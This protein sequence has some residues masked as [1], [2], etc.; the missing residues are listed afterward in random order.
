MTHRG[1]AIRDRS[2]QR[3]AF[4]RRR[5]GQLRHRAPR[6]NN[7][8]KRKGWLAPSLQHRIDTTMAWVR[9]LGHLVAE[10]PPGRWSGPTW[11]QGMSPSVPRAAWLC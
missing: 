5:R 2:A 3:R 4:R 10:S 6:F 1:H 11:V 9:R 8:T 7:R